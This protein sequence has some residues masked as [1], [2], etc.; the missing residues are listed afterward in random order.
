ML[1]IYL[2]STLKKMVSSLTPFFWAPNNSLTYLGIQLTAPSNDILIT[3]YNRVVKNLNNISQ[4]MKHLSECICLCNRVLQL[5]WSTL[6]I[7]VS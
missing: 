6:M 1:D 7:A 5:W 2:D 4:D 3:N